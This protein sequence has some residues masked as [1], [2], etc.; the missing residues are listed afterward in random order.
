MA[1]LSTLH[2]WH[3]RIKRKCNLFFHKVERRHD[4]QIRKIE[5]EIENKNLKDPPPPDEIIE[6]DTEGGFD[7]TNTSSKQQHPQTQKTSGQRQPKKQKQKE[8]EQQRQWLTKEIKRQVQLACDDEVQCLAQ[9]Q[10][11]ELFKQSVPLPPLPPPPQLPT[12]QQSTTPNQ[13][14]TT[15]VEFSETVQ[16]SNGTTDR[17]TPG[18]PPQQTPDSTAVAPWGTT[19]QTTNS[20]WGSAARQQGTGWG[21]SRLN[22]TPSEQTTGG[23]TTDLQSAD[24]NSLTSTNTS[25]AASNS[26]SPTQTSTPGSHNTSRG[27]QYFHRGFQ[28]SGRGHRSWNHYNRGGRGRGQGQ[29]RGRGREGRGRGRGRGREGRGWDQATGRNND[30]SEG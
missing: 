17:L 12:N 7:T 2:E 18:N 21:M 25:E 15:G 30:A 8:D 4:K 1:G 9:L 3:C 11:Q 13:N 20:G 29:G 19:T 24:H 6:I 23:N 27:E 28:T 5:T 26:E 10:A 22:T 16:N 14:F